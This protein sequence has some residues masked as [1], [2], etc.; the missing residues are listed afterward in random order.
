MSLV[1]V[2]AERR[3]SLLPSRGHQLLKQASTESLAPVS[4][5][6]DKR[7]DLSH[8]CAQARQLAAA[9]NTCRAGRDPEAGHVQLHLTE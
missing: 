9:N 2:G 4:L 5:D 7:T 3:E 1:G 6:D 8:S